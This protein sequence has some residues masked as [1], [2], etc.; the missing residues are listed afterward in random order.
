MSAV[1]ALAAPGG[2]IKIGV[3]HNVRKR[4]QELRGASP[5]PL[6]LVC[7]ARCGSDAFAGPNARRVEQLAH[8]TLGAHRLHGE[9]FDIT[10]AEAVAA[11]TMAAAAAVVILTWFDP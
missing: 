2:P 4:V 8:E 9:W 11:I 3:S 10:E 5:A 1:Y 6:T 7:A